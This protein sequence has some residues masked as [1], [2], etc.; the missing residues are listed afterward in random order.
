MKIKKISSA[1]DIP[2]EE[3]EDWGIPKTIGEPKCQLSGLF[4][5]ENEDGSEA[6]IWECTPGKF[7]REVMQAELVT[8]LSGH[9]IFHPENGDP[10]EIKGGDV[11]FFPGKSLKRFERPI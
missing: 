11:L 8:F 2:S 7:V 9:C 3:L 1:A 4:I 6:G 10:V 5:S